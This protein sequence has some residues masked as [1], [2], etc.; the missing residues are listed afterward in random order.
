M[1]INTNTT[2]TVQ[3]QETQKAD[4]TTTKA[5]KF[6]ETLKLNDLGETELKN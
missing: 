2:T 6:L 4:G 3:V 1:E 5:E